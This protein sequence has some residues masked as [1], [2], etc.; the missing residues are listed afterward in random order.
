MPLSQDISLDGLP[1]TVVPGR[2]EKAN[3]PAASGELPKEVKRLVL[4]PFSRGQR[5][6]LDSRPPTSDS[7]LATAGWDSAGVG[8]CFDG[9]GVEPW[10]N[11]TSF[12]DAN[13]LD[14]P[15]AG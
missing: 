6:A 7:R 9:Q 11:A 13:L 4:G 15:S 1:Y 2:Y 5:Q 10:P 8:P 12:A 3:A 14:V